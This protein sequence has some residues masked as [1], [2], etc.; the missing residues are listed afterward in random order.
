MSRGNE[1][2][3]MTRLFWKELPEIIKTIDKNADAR[4]ILLRGEGKHF[5]AGMDLANFVNDGSGKKKKDPSRTRE[6]FYHEL[7]ELQ[8]AFTALEK[9]R[10]PT[11]AAIQG[12]CVG[13]AIDMAAACDMRYC[14]TDA[15]YKIAEVDIGIA[16]DVG[17]LQRLPTLMPLGAVRELAYTG[18][19]FDSAEAQ[20]LGF[21]EKVFQ[22]HDQL[23]EETTKLA[24]EIASKSPLV[25]SVIKKQI[26]Y[27]RD[28]SVD[29][30]LDYHAIWNSALISSSDM[31][32]AMKAY[33]EKVS[34]DFEDLEPKKSFWEKQGLIS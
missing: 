9:C 32:S 13:G 34:G 8:G 17:T 16:A 22:D 19:K 28:N 25:T 24:E 10:M 23:L 5:S 29:D 33:M 18:R 14:S 26:N 12:A 11:I 31:E 20:Q 4:V 15:F 7:L 2:N 30:A 1:L 21:V 6:A 27:A 3:T